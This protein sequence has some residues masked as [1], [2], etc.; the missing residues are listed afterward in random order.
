MYLFQRLKSS[1]VVFVCYGGVLP[2]IIFNYCNWYCHM[3]HISGTAHVCI[4]VEY[5]LTGFGHCNSPYG[6]CDTI[7]MNCSALLQGF[8]SSVLLV[9]V[10]TKISSGGL[11]S[12]DLANHWHSV[13]APYW[14]FCLYVNDHCF[15]ILL[16]GGLY[17]QD[18]YNHSNNTKRRFNLYF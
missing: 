9:L 6:K 7:L 11:K 12:G 13:L 17:I 10:N 14:S 16:G 4:V 18:G 15:T 5:S 3:I 1:Y 2:I 8:Y